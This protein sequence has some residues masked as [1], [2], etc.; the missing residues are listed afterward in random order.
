MKYLN[1]I[2]TPA[3]LKCPNFA[4]H[5]IVVGTLIPAF[6]AKGFVWIDVDLGAAN[7]GLA[8]PHNIILVKILTA[9]FQYPRLT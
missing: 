8:F 6:C 5:G 3:C 9:L 7:Q 1:R 4:L 2:T